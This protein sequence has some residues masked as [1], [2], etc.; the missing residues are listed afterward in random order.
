M[1]ADVTV[2]LHHL[3]EGPG[4]APVLVVANSLGTTLSMWDDQAPA[5][6]DHFRLLQEVTRAVLYHLESVSRNGG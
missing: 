2:E 3:L 5:L 4:E 6:R 1:T